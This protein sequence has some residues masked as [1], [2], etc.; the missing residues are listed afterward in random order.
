MK[1]HV[2]APF[3]LYGEEQ[4]Q[5][6]VSQIDGHVTRFYGRVPLGVFLNDVW[7]SAKREGYLAAWVDIQTE[8]YIGEYGYDPPLNVV[9]DWRKRAAKSAMGESDESVED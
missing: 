3:T 6:L 9:A 4:A 5:E 2:K 8:L 7:Q 1:P